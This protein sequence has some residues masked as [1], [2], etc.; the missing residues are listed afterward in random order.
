MASTIN[1]TGYICGAD[2][3]KIEASI[4]QK[5]IAPSYYNHEVSYIVPHRFEECDGLVSVGFDN[6]LT[7][8]ES[9]FAGCD[10]L[11]TVAF[12]NATSIEANVFLSCTSLHE[13]EFGALTPM[14]ASFSTSTIWTSVRFDAITT[15]PNSRSNNF[16]TFLSKAKATLQSIYFNGITGSI[17]SYYF[18]TFAALTTAEFKNASA[19]IASYAFINCTNLKTIDIS[20]AS[21]AQRNAFQN[22]YA[23]ESITLRG[24]TGIGIQAFINCSA[25]SY[26]SI[27][28]GNT[29][30][31]GCF[32][33]CSSLKSFS[34]PMVT[35]MSSSRHF[36]NCTGLSWVQFDQMAT[37]VGNR[38]NN[39]NTVY[40]GATNI[41]YIGFRQ[42]T[43]IPSYY[44]A[45]YFHLK[46]I[47][48]PLATTVSNYAFQY[49]SEL[50]RVDLPRAQTLG[51]YAFRGCTSLS[52]AKFLWLSKIG[53]NTFN[54]CTNLTK[55]YLL[56]SSMTVLTGS[57]NNFTNAGITA[58]AGTIFVPESLLATYQANGSW[59]NYS[60]RF[61]AYSF[62]SF[63]TQV[64][65]VL[66]KVLNNE[67]IPCYSIASNASANIIANLSAGD[68]VIV[69]G[70]SN[71]YN[72]ITIVSTDLEDA[73]PPD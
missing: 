29:L 69:T 49:N 38:S 50:T 66:S 32:E 6:V 4:I 55:L 21:G 27:G 7:I 44:F 13:I 45:S 51:T 41:E 9:A 52:V 26:I 33:N 64:R 53:G 15:L 14:P 58:D 40:L 37:L 10:A 11:E 8:G 57:T 59:K 17:P 35:T 19:Q 31:S 43:T 25:L 54:G 23:L 3:L 47:S 56:G 60:T 61:S 68:Q 18:S 46:S 48:F 20:L 39:S 70:F 30:G 5:T 65:Y 72:A 34:G 1:Q 67:T 2:N 24:P 62:P 42:P 22:C 12:K 63:S 16:G 71:A 36:A 28:S 73:M